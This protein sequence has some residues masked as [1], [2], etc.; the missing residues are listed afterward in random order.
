MAVVAVAGLVSA[1]AVPV[2]LAVPIPV[3]LPMA[4]TVLAALDRPGTL[5]LRHATGGLRV[6]DGAC[7]GAGAHT[8]R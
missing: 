1:L 3:A 2:A 8:A 4:V 6:G 5:G 7:L